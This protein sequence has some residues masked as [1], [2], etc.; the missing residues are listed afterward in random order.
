MRALGIWVGDTSSFV[1]NHGMRAIEKA[2]FLNLDR[3][4]A[5]AKSPLSH[6]ACE[7]TRLGTGHTMMAMMQEERRAIRD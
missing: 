6:G 1:K 5:V 7:R 4:F 3:R 2:L